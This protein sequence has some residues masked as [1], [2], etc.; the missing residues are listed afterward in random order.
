MQGRQDATFGAV[1][2]KALPPEIPRLASVAFAW[3]DNPKPI[4]RPGMFV[5]VALE[6]AW[7]DVIV[8]PTE[9]IVDDGVDETV[10][11]QIGEGEFEPRVVDSPPL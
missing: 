8:V 1:V 3:M 4:L 9:A 5:D 2:A 10:F 6:V 7:P 11:V